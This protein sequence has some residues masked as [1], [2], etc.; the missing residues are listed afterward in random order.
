MQRRVAGAP[1]P[2]VRE[3]R[4]PRAFEGFVRGS[5]RGVD[6]RER[7]RRF[8]FKRQSRIVRRVSCDHVPRDVVPRETGRVLVAAAQVENP[9]PSEPRELQR[10]LDVSAIRVERDASTRR[11]DDV[12][13]SAPQR[14]PPDGGRGDAFAPNANARFILET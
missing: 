1:R 3:P 11:G 5:K 14:A 4:P 9:E 12:R 13:Q 8:A 2:S 6:A 7:V 10:V